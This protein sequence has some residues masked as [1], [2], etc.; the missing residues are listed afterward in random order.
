MTSLADKTQAVALALLSSGPSPI[1]PPEHR[2]IFVLGG[3]LQ[4]VTKEG[5]VL[6]ILCKTLLLFMLGMYSSKSGQF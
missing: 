6:G 1:P 2:L 4:P 3:S 5:Q